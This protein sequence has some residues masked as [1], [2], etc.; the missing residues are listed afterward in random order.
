MKKIVV[1]AITN[2]YSAPRGVLQ[3]NPNWEYIMFVD[4]EDM[5]IPAPWKKIVIPELDDRA[6]KILTHK[7]L[8]GWDVMIWVDGSVA[9]L[10]DPDT[11]L[12]TLGKYNMLTLLHT[13]C[14]NVFEDL[15]RIIEL[16]KADLTRSV[17][18]FATLSFDS[19]FR[20]GKYAELGFFIRKNNEETNQM[21]EAW[22]TEFHAMGIRRDQ[23]AFAAAAD[24]SKIKLLESRDCIKAFHHSKGQELKFEYTQPSKVWFLQLAS[25]SKEIQSYVEEATAGYDEQDWICLTD[26]DMLFFNSDIGKQITDIVNLHRDKVQLLGCMTNR[27]GLKWQIEHPGLYDEHNIRVHAAVARELRTKWQNEITILNLPVAG[28]CMLF[29]VWL[30]RN[31][32]FQ[33]HVSEDSERGPI[34]FDYDFSERVIQAGGRSGLMRGV[35]AYHAYQPLQTDRTITHLV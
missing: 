2:N 14:A 33:K 8:G 25:S 19:R 9:F 24:W 35:Y 21:F 29:P 31:F 34:F 15:N 4:R 11:I 6:V 10:E 26:I 18:L 12:I 3:H 30:L 5:D 7:F 1:S 20:V 16:G 13:R 32:G 28:L 27:L 17:E 23:P 22:A